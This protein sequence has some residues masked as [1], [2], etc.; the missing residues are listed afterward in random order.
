MNRKIL[1]RMG[2]V[3]RL[4]HGIEGGSRMGRAVRREQDHDH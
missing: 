3:G 2:T 1:F 4:A